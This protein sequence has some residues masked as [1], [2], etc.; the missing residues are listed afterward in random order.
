VIFGAGTAGVG[1][2]DQLRDAM[3]R[4]GLDREQATRRVWLVDQQG[5]LIDAMDGLRDFQ[6]PYARPAA[7]AYGLERDDGA[8]TLATTVAAARPTI[9]IGTSKQGGAFTEGVIREMAAHVD[10]PLIFPLS[11]PTEKF[12]SGKIEAHPADLV[13]WTEGRALIGTGTPWDPVPFGGIEIGIGQANNALLYPG[14]GLGTVVARAKHVTAGMI[15][16]AAEAVAG[17]VETGAPG[18]PLLPAV[19][20]L[21]AVSATVAVAVVRRA[22][23]EGVARVAPENVVQAVQDAIWVPAYPE[24]DR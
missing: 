15:R 13:A 1:I 4:A 18:A 10:R 16:A 24:L 14:L 17:L 11:N 5:L 2:A 12:D 20:D 3:V 7:D 21:R 23:A 9:L 19:A 8:I 22:V 6:V